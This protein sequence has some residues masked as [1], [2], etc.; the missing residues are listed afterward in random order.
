MVLDKGGPWASTFDLQT[1]AS[2][3]GFGVFVCGR[4]EWDD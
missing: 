2:V 1:M 4:D 3:L